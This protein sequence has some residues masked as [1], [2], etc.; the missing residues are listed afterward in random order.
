MSAAV[1]KKIQTCALRVTGQAKSATAESWLRVTSATALEKGLSEMRGFGLILLLTAGVGSFTQAPTP[2]RAITDAPAFAR[3]KYV[4]AEINELRET[5]AILRATIER[6]EESQCPTDCPGGCSKSETTETLNV[7]KADAPE[8]QAEITDQPSPKAAIT[9][10]KQAY[11]VI[12]Q[13]SRPC[14]S[15]GLKLGRSR[16]SC[17]GGRCRTKR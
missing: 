5:I 12:R 16:R 4:D 8:T 1:A 15:K 3:Q 17:S 9:K 10:T 7:T 13:P 14:Y 2:V 11:W 6:L